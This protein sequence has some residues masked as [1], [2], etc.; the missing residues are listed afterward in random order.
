MASGAS[1]KNSKGLLAA[2]VESAC[3]RMEASSPGRAPPAN[4]SNSNDSGNGGAATRTY[5]LT[6]NDLTGALLLSIGPRVNAEQVRGLYTRLV[7]D[8]VVAEW[9]FDWHPPAG[10]ADCPPHQDAA[11]NIE[12]RQAP[13]SRF[14]PQPADDF[15]HPPLALVGPPRIH[16]GGVAVAGAV[17]GRLDVERPAG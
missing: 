7:R 3:K 14:V 16:L 12:K 11:G 13:A 15:V 5:T 4:T 17:L 1:A 9:R 2:A 8:E 6:H 10:L